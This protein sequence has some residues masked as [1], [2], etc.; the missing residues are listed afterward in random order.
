M[1]NWCC[2]NK[3]TTSHKTQYAC[4]IIKLKSAQKKGFEGD[5]M[6]AMFWWKRGME[7]REGEGKKRER[8]HRRNLVFQVSLPSNFADLILFS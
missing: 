5:T 2:N 8:N 3:S 1:S 4:S 6:H 7:M